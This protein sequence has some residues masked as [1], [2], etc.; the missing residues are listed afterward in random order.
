MMSTKAF[1]RHVGGV[2]IK[3]RSLLFARVPQAVTFY[4]A[5]RDARLELESERRVGMYS[6]GGGSRHFVVYYTNL[7]FSGLGTLASCHVAAAS[8]K[9]EL[10][11]FDDQF[12]VKTGDETKAGS[13]LTPRVQEELLCL[14]Q[15]L[16]RK[17][18]E[19]SSSLV[20]G[21]LKGVARSYGRPWQANVKGELMLEDGVLR[22]RYR[23][24]LYSA[25]D[26]MTFYEFG[27]RLYAELEKES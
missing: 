22:L 19:K 11:S 4:H 24:L 3:V 6:E 26:L 1:A 20:F 10:D 2:V 15:W 17:E 5:G 13:I 7:M 9:D 18:G 27:Q 8:R 25:V 23:G 16:A 21:R 12:A 14:K